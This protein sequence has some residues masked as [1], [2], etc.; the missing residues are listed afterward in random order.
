MEVDVQ[1][2]KKQKEE[3]S[4]LKLIPYKKL[5]QIIENND[6]SFVP[7]PEEYKILFEFIKK[8]FFNL[9]GIVKE[10]GDSHRTDTTRNW[11]DKRN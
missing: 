2:I 4:E 7:H 9:D 6:P 10:R 1:N 5:K 11:C 8:Y 3:V